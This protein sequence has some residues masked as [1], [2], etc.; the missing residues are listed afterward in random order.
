MK[1][2]DVPKAFATDEQCVAYLEA[3]R[4]PYGIR[5]TVCGAKEIS[6]ITPLVR[7]AR[8]LN[9][10]IFLGKEGQTSHL[11]VPLVTSFPSSSSLN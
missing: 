3:M 10:R 8:E 11:F 1:L 9:H 2:L 5:C 6:T 7:P 4:W